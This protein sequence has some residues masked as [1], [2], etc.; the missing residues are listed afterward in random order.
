MRNGFYRVLFG[1]FSLAHQFFVTQNMD[2]RA[3]DIKQI[4]LDVVRGGDIVSMIWH[5]I[6]QKDLKQISMFQQA[7]EA[8]LSDPAWFLDLAESLCGRKRSPRALQVLKMLED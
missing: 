6:N 7:L 4:S 8:P 1:W 3:W 2:E 5:F